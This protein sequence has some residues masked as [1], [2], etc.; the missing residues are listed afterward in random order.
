MSI[1]PTHGWR[2]R[3]GRVAAGPLCGG[4]ASRAACGTGERV[5][6]HDP[7]RHAGREVLAVWNGPERRHLPAL[8]SRADQSL[9]RQMPN[10]W[11]SASSQRHRRAER[12]A[13]ADHEAEFELVV[14]RA[15]GQTVGAFRPG[16]IAWPSGRRTGVPLTTTLDDAR[17]WYAHGSQWKLASRRSRQANSRPMF[18][19]WWI[20]CRSR[21]SCRCASAGS[22]A[23]PRPAAR[24]RPAPRRPAP[25]WRRAAAGRR[26]RG[27]ARAS[28]PGRGR[29][30]VQR[31]PGRGGERLRGTPSTTPGAPAPPGQHLVADRDP[32]VERRS[33]RRRNTR[34][35]GSGSESPS[36]GVGRRQP[37]AR[38]R[39]CEDRCDGASRSADEGCG[40]LGSGVASVVEDRHRRVVS[41]RVP[42][43]RRGSCAGSS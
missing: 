11:S 31:R 19:A 26:A 24:G 35:A 27:A 28:A 39:S 3:G 32:A 1:A 30:I 34:S 43:T 12:V 18:S 6:R 21:C 37:A 20:E 36:L 25:A 38:R 23:R 29:V 14:S 2:R 7:R 16:G 42:P 4:R 10:R 15:Q 8:M 13:R 40:P 22:Y 33:P 17:P 9:S 5:Q 41:S